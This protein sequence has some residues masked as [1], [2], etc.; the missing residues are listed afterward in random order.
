M[1]RGR[2]SWEAVEPDS[3]NLSLPISID[4]RSGQVSSS[5]LTVQCSQG[6]LVR[7]IKGL[8]ALLRSQTALH[9]ALT[10]NEIAVA[11]ITRKARKEYG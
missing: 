10:A 2:L 5:S 6:P 11:R 9:D 3:T 8:S 4:A 7:G 1:I